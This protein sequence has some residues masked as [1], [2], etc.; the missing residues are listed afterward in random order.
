MAN[1]IAVPNL[2]LSD[3]EYTDEL[4]LNELKLVSGGWFIDFK[5]RIDSKKVEFNQKVEAIN[6]PEASILQEVNAT[7]V[8]S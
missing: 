8:T 6:S 5:T 3:L 4:T 7:L 1:S 2:V